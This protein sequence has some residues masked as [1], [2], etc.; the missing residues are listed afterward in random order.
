MPLTPTQEHL[1]E[2]WL[3]K[4]NQHGDPRRRKPL[5]GQDIVQTPE[6]V[7]LTPTQEILLEDWLKRQKTPG[8]LQRRRTPF[9]QSISNT[10]EPPIQTQGSCLG[11]RK[12]AADR[13]RCQ[14]PAGH[15]KNQN[16]KWS[17]D[18]WFEKRYGDPGYY[19]RIKGL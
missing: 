19:S 10:H 13:Q 12:E 11:K 15:R 2:T 8:Y 18:M 5:G 17:D 14:V 3:E 16:P 9:E 7:P 4:H 6:P 1:L